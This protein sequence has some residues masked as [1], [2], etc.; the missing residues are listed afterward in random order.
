MLNL[1]FK[2]VFKME[3]R[4]YNTKVTLL[5]WLSMSLLRSLW[6]VETSYVGELAQSGVPRRSKGQLS[7]DF[8]Q[9]NGNA[10]CSLVE[11]SKPK[12]V[13][14]CIYCDMDNFLTSK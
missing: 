5:L 9:Y 10:L 6:L 1:R 3:T 4:L 13:L 7:C 14:W 2:V 8:N 12:K 11:I